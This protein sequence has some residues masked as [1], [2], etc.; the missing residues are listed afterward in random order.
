MI[1][2]LI[3]Y[4]RVRELGEVF[5]YLGKE[6]VLLFEDIDPQYRAIKALTNACGDDAQLLVVLN[7]LISYRL[8]M[9][10]EEYWDTFSRYFSSRCSEIR[11]EEL[12]N[13]FKDFIQRFNRV[14]ASQKVSRVEKAIKC[15]KLAEVVYKELLGSAWRAIASCLGSE[16]EGKTIVFAVKMLYYARKALGRADEVPMEIPIP[17]DGRIALITY[18]SGALEV[19][20]P[21]INREFLMMYSDAI[22][23]IWSEVGKYSNISPLNLDSVVW[24]FGKYTS[25]GSRMRIVEEAYKELKNIMALNDVELI[26]NNLFYRLPP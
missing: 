21:R 9:T 11:F 4:A 25:V 13:V 2:T 22:R 24:F 16:P 10:G 3:N 7:A 15:R 6:K 14:L 20:A 26:V 8:V 18:Y 5:R 19:S 1:L 17:V 23:S 12:V